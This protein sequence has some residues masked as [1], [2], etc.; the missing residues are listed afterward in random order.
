VAI[1]GP[2]PAMLNAL[3]INISDFNVI[4]FFKFPHR[5]SGKQNRQKLSN[6]TGN[7]LQAMPKFWT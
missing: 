1:P 4:Y 5:L 6:Y 3:T 7:E 2:L